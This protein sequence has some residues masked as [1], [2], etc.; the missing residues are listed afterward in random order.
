MT[1]IEKVWVYLRI[2]SDSPKGYE[3][4]MI[5]WLRDPT[6][7][8]LED[9]RMVALQRAT[10]HA[11][12]HVEVSHESYDD[13]PP[14]KGEERVITKKSSFY[15]AAHKKINDLPDAIGNLAVMVARELATRK[16]KDDFAALPPPPPKAT[17]LIQ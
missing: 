16:I 17:P 2:P 14:A 9:A 12:L 4:H 6:P 5:A 8:Q 1:I 10:E 3:A 13:A 11:I 15:D 7:S